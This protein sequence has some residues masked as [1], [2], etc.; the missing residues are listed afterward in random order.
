MGFRPL[1]HLKDPKVHLPQAFRARS[2]PPSG[3]DYPL[4]GF[5][6]SNP[7]RPCFMPTALM[8]FTLRSVPPLEGTR[9][10]PPARTHLPFRLAV[11]WLPEQQAGPPSPGFWASAL[12]GIPCV[13][14]VFSTP[15]AGCSLGFS[16]PG[17]SRRRPG[18]KLPPNSSLALRKAADPKGQ[19]CVH[20]RVSIG[21]RLTPSGIAAL[22]RRP[23]KATPSG[24]PCRYDPK[25]SVESTPGL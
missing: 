10:F 9:T 23:D 8:G 21:L 1:Q 7:R 13:R 12:P 5:L 24:F 22:L 16:P 14:R 6:P 18:S 19:N 20:L 2:V 25:H 15:N 11:N 17:V 3:F 4:D